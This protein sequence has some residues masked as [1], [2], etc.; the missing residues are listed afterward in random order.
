MLCFLGTFSLKI[1]L[2]N[3]RSTEHFNS[4]SS[5]MEPPDDQSTEHF[6]SESSGIVIEEIGNCEMIAES[7][8]VGENGTPHRM[9]PTIELTDKDI[10][11]ML[12]ALR[13]VPD[14]PILPNGQT[15]NTEMD[16]DLREVLGLD[17]GY[18]TV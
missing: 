14:A 6:N 3:F 8:D 1:P 15:V 5:S 12:S 11:E 18:F 16:E 13:S 17:V 9:Q 2:I 4:E 10:E 7:S